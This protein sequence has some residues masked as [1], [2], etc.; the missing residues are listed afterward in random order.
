M[1]DELREAA[2][3]GGVP[4]R[5]LP[6]KDSHPLARAAR[7]VSGEAPASSTG[8]SSLLG[9]EREANEA[10]TAF[11][12]FGSGLESNLIAAVAERGIRTGSSRVRSLGILVLKKGTGERS[13]VYH[14]QP[15][16]DEGL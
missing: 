5:E 16:E 3:S 7:R 8:A 1:E 12:P 14:R 15:G 13:A 2:Q 9:D 4:P 11:S 10:A 6:R